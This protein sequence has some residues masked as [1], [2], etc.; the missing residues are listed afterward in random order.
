MAS[1][2]SELLKVPG[3]EFPCNKDFT[4]GAGL[5]LEDKSDCLAVLLIWTENRFLLDFSK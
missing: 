3:E 1:C 5:E 4:A 2:D